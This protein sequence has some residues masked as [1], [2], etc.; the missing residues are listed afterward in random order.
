M[1]DPERIK[2]CDA[3]GPYYEYDVCPSCEAL[4]F[5]A[6]ALDQERNIANV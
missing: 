6:D 4:A 1:I 3:H 2:N 5:E